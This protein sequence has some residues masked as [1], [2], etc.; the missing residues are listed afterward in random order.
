MDRFSEFEIPSYEQWRD[1]TEKSLK[2]ASFEKRLI[3]ETYEGILLQPMYRKEDAAN[4]PFLQSLPGMAPFTRG[5]KTLI[6]G[7]EINQEINVGIPTSFNKVARHDLSKGQ[8]SL[9]IVLDTPTKR[10][11]N[12]NEATSEVGKAGLSISGVTD[13]AD[14]LKD[15]DLSIVPIHVS[16]GVNSLPILA[17]IIAHLEQSGRQVEEL[18]GCIGMD[19][20]AELVENGTLAYELEDCYTLMADITKWA[21]ENTPHLQTVLIHGNVYHDGGSSAVEELAFSL[22]TGVEYLQALTSQ[23]IDINKAASSIRF[24]FSIGSGY[25]MEIAKLRAARNLWARIVETFGGNEEA[26]KMTMHAR[27]SAWTKTVFDPYVNILRATTEAFSAAVGGADSIHVSCFDEAIQKSTAFSRRIARNA[28]IILKEEAH[29]ARTIDP[30]GGSWYVEVLTNEVAKK[31]WGLFQETERKGGIIQS[32][33]KK[34]PQNVVQQTAS[35]RVRSIA[36]RKDIFVGTNMYVNLAEKGVDWIALN[37]TPQ[38]N[39]HINQVVGRAHISVGSLS[40][41]SNKTETAI[42]AAKQG[43]SLGEIAKATGRKSEAA[44]CVKAI[45]PTR[46]TLQFEELRQ[47]IDEMAQKTGK[48]P[49]IFLAN[50]G[51][52]SDHKVR[53][54]FA[55]GFFEVGG[56]DVIQNNGFG[57]IKEAAEAVVASMADFVIIC[58]KD[59]DYQQAAIPLAMSIKK[60]DAQITILLAGKPSEVEEVRFKEAGIT[61][62]VHVGSN[63]YDILSQ[64]LQKKGVAVS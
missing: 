45:K 5:T 33:I 64:L 51:P 28:S 3:T 35:K 23:G 43:A 47:S 21:N 6:N 55:A 24:A 57:S 63:C 27:T 59:E 42:E 11:I 53:A 44:V 50:L 10:G 62:F 13:I 15:I 40:V 22:S 56:F 38:I 49:I 4:L 8:T 18:H 9:N 48:R 26:Q 17:L 34:F 32:L 29:I 7:W 58:G 20:V 41:S 30:A 37:E 54:D 25:F 2:G 46:G 16:A 39:D 60:T 1:L 61:E 14:A 52:I 19:P 12:A 31:A 36:H